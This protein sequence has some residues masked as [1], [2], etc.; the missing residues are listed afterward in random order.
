MKCQ[1]GCGEY[2][3]PGNRFIHGHNA[4]K[5]GDARRSTK[6]PEYA[7][8]AHMIY[9]CTNPQS[10]EWKYYGGRGVQ[11]CAAWQNFEAFLADVG[12]RPSPKHSIDRYPD[13]DG[14]YEPGN[15]RWATLVEQH[16][17]T[18][19]NRLIEFHGRSQC[20]QAWADELG[21]GYQS[22]QYRLRHGLPLDWPKGGRT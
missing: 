8:W 20:L 10:K 22:V 13:K 2:A 14:D 4:V 6:S 9:R 1:C 7:V 12:R 18:G 17:N 5:H 3:R 19:R 21:V 15:V 16:R 11:V